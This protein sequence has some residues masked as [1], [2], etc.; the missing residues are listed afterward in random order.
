M[1]D[2]KVRA[3]VMGYFGHMWELCTMWVL[4]LFV[5]AT[6]I[7]G[8]TL[9]WVAFGVLASGAVGCVAGGWLALRMGSARVAGIQLAI[10]GLCCIA[11]PWMLQASTPFFFG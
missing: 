11:A 5:L 1:T 9:S 4:V 3:S 10:S 7:S 6:R 8:A 2:A